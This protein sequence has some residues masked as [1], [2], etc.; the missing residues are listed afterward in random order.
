MGRITLNDDLITAITKMSDRVPGALDVMAK[1][2]EETP[3]VDPDCAFAMIKIMQLDDLGIY[4][5][6]IWMLYKDVCDQH[7]DVMIGLMRGVQLGHLS[8]WDLNRAIDF[9]TTISIIDVIGAVQRE[10]PNFKMHTDPQLL[11]DQG[12]SK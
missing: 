9:R 6:R 12:V 3:T 8:E 2:L 7:I 5:S 10:L 11:V 1:L 4:G